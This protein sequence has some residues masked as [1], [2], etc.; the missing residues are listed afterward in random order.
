MNNLENHAILKEI[1]IDKN[2]I[3]N[4]QLETEEGTKRSKEKFHAKAVEDRNEYVNHQKNKFEEYR[5][6]IENEMKKRI[7]QLM[8]KDKS[9]EYQQGIDEV[10]QLLNLVKLNA[11]ISNSFKLGLDFIMT[12]ITEDTSL[13]EFNNIIKRFIDRFKELDIVL[14]IEDFKYTMFTEKYM[15][16]FFKDSSLDMMKDVFEKIYFTCPD[17]K[18]QLK[19]N[20][21][22]IVEKYS[23]KLNK[24]VESLNRKLLEEY[25]ATPSNVIEKYTVVRYKSGNEVAIDPYYNTIIFTEGKKK[26]DDYV[27]G[28]AAREKNYNMFAVNGNYN[29]LNDND[30]ENYNSA[31]MGLYLTLNELKKFYNYEF[32]LK[33]LL[34]RYKD[35]DSAKGQYSSKKKEIDKQEKKRTSLYKDYLKASGVGLFARKNEVKMK[36]VML[37]MNEQVRTLQTLYKEYRDLEITNQ[38]SKINE[39][40]SIYDLFMVATTSFRF[41][42]KNF[43]KDEHFKDKSLDKS[44]EENVNEYFKFIYNPN[45][46]V[47]RKINV[48]ANYDIVSVVAEKYKILKLTVTSEMINKDNIDAT[49][50][51]VRF[52]NLIQNINRSA[53]SIHDIDILCKM[54]EIVDKEENNSEEII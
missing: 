46:S 8:P 30:K 22:Y 42:E 27:E 16:S 20:L 19:L 13:E 21:F 47:L 5:V 12:A 23:D 1:E 43:E 32:I 52:I 25:E 4:F 49:M 54:K 31:I 15:L 35:K 51:S 33:D 28:A 10:D 36:D 7:E 11:N 44:L 14:T 40:A 45:N 53:I 6:E 9:A 26:I 50:E 29:E 3:E 39:S 34:N 48:F 17:I 41:L 37:K 38:L 24:Y 18:L 2:H